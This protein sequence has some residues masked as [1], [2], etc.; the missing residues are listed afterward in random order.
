MKK[1]IVSLAV[2]FSM[3]ANAAP[4][5]VSGKVLDVAVG[6]IS[7]GWGDGCLLLV[8]SAS[9]K[10]FTLIADFDECVEGRIEDAEGKSIYVPAEALFF[11]RSK[12]E[13]S[14]L[15]NEFGSDSFYLHV[16]INKAKFQ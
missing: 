5:A 7:V 16:L 1:I 10:L 11:I 4:K 6:E 9:G 13:I 12:E 15:K 14:D 8:E 2:L 3:S